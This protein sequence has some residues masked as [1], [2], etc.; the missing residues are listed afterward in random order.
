MRRYPRPERDGL[1]QCGCGQKTKVPDRTSIRD[2]AFR[3]VPRKYLHGHHLKGETPGRFINTHGY[4]LVWAPDHPD[5]PKQKGYV[6]EHRLVMERTLGRHLTS[7]EGVHHINHVKTDNRPENLELVNRVE[8]GKKH[9][10]PR[11]IP[12]TPEQRE[13]HRARMREWWASRR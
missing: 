4:V 6:L 10:R 3:G 2:G 9:G 5:A 12:M 13:R 1:C 11:G 8:H 7:A